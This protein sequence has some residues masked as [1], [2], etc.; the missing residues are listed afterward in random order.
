MTGMYV[1]KNLKKAKVAKEIFMGTYCILQ[2]SPPGSQCLHK[3]GMI[4]P[5]RLILGC[6]MK[7]SI[8]FVFTEIFLLLRIFSD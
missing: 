1:S 4:V 7:D 5:K 6:D 8:N 2:S 3:F